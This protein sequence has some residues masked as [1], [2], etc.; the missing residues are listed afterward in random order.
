MRACAA[1]QAREGKDIVMT[2]SKTF[3]REGRVQG[4]TD[5]GRAR[6]PAA[7]AARVPLSQERDATGPHPSNLVGTH[8]PDDPNPR[9]VGTRRSRAISKSSIVTT[10][11]AIL[12]PENTDEDELLM[13]QMAENTQRMDLT[14]LDIAHTLTR[15]AARFKPRGTTQKQLAQRMGIAQ[16]RFTKYL[17]L[18]KAPEE[19]QT[20]SS[21]DGIQ[22]LNLLYDLNKTYQAEPKATLAML[23]K[24]RKDGQ[25]TPLR[26]LVDKL[27]D[28]APTTAVAI[29]I[30]SGD[31]DPH[32]IFEVG[33]KRG[34]CALPPHI[35][36]QL[37]HLPR[38]HR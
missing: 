13:I 2:D 15:L 1:A 37:H 20:L 5:T 22:D 32:L 25:N 11:T 34:S 19:I 31:T 35:L 3:A 26:P 17:A 12:R 10:I 16:S 14:S 33:Q 28:K 36:A 9:R 27:L 7:E 38:K 4:L 6:R 18:S 30:R 8:T 24:W 21:N 29:E 23:A